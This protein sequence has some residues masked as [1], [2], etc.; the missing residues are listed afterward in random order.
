MYRK[1]R[2]DVLNTHIHT[3]HIMKKRESKAI[4]VASCGGPW[5]FETLRIP[6]FLDNQLTDG[7]EVN[8]FNPQ[9][10]SWYY[11]LLDAK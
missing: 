4:P 7:S 8:S 2:H 5:G 10:Y 6:H 11:F 1:E 9:E 3:K